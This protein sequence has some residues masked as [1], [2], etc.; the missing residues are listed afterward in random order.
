MIIIEYNAK[1]IRE[2]YKNYLEVDVN[3][4]KWSIQ[5]D[6]RLWAK[7]SEMGKVWK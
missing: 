2:R 7:V 5:E 6:L 4:K 3:R 1:K